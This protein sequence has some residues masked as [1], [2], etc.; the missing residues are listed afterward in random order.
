MRKYLNILFLCTLVLGLSSCETDDGDDFYIYDTLV[1]GIW[2]GDLGFADN[3]NSALESGLYLK[4]TVWEEMNR[5]ITMI[6]T[7]KLCSACLSVG[8]CTAES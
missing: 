1:G 8:M 4:V 2:L 6:R 7:E 3:Y 5:H